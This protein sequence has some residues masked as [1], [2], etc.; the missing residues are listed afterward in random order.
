VR[1]FL[2]EKG[3]PKWQLPDA[4]ELVD[5]IPRTSVGKF[6]KKAL[7]ARYGAPRDGA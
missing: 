3:F 4:L 5:E 2:L 6:D 1:E 7:R